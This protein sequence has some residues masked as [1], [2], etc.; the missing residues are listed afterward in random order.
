MAI[1]E[2]KGLVPE[3]KLRHLVS[4]K[5]VVGFAPSKSLIGFP[6]LAN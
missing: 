2:E 6:D 3:D 4:L 1:R 5:K